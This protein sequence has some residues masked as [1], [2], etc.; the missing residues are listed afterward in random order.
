MGDLVFLPGSGLP[1]LHVRMTYGQ[2]ET[3]AQRVILTAFVPCLVSVLLL[4]VLLSVAQEEHQAAL[5][6]SPAHPKSTLA[7]L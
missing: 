6:H 7:E 5:I 2:S 1:L 3:E 4:H